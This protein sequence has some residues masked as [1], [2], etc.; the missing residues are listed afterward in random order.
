[1]RAITVTAAALLATAA[2]AACSDRVDTVSG[3]AAPV[4]AAPAGS[5][6]P[7]PTV[8]TP[9][10]TTPPAAGSAKTTTGAAAPKK[11]CPVT[12]ATLYRA[13]K[14]DKSMWDR[15]ATPTGLEK[16]TCAEGYATAI[17]IVKNVDPAGVLFKYDPATAAWKP[18]NLGSGGYCEGYVKQSLAQRLGN[19]C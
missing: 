16:A 12:A 7:A 13:L 19:G 1:M 10:A 15:T 17:T 3:E 9:A 18:L 14:A 5:A 11:A 8:T 4:T 2:L 6:A